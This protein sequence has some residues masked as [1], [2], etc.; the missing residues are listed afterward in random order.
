M[1]ENEEHWM[2]ALTRSNVGEEVKQRMMET[3]NVPEDEVDRV[4]TAVNTPEYYQENKNGFTEP[5][6]T[7]L[8]GKCLWTLQ[9]EGKRYKRAIE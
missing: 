1:A 6:K 5:F 4:L 9:N 7:N 3:Y 2:D 8:L